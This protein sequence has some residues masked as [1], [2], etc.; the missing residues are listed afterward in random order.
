MYKADRRAGLYLG[1]TL[2]LVC[3]VA[4]ASLIVSCSSNAAKDGPDSIA[5]PTVAAAKV[6]R[7]DLTR[8]LAVTAEFRPYQVIDVH[9]KVSGYVKRI[10]VDV[11]DRVKEGQ[12]IAVLEI[13]EL[14]DDVQTAEAP[15]LLAP[16]GFL[17]DSC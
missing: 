1:T 9:A 17:P 8:A 7:T 14:Q 6:L 10:Y 11:G 5:A 4:S 3:Y 16:A 13:P 15:G 2:S 12:L